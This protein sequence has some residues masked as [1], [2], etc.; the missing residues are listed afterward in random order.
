MIFKELYRDITNFVPNIGALDT[1]NLINNAISELNARNFIQETSLYFVADT[2]QTPAEI[3]LSS[4]SSTHNTYKGE[5]LKVKSVLNCNSY[6]LKRKGYGKEYIENIASNGD[7][8]YGQIANTI[9][10]KVDSDSYGY[11]SYNLTVVEKTTNTITDDDDGDWTTK[12]IS[13]GSYIG[14]TGLTESVDNG[15]YRVAEINDSNPGVTSNDEIK[16]DPAVKEIANGEESK[17]E[18]AVYPL[19]RVIAFIAIPQFS[20]NSGNPT[21][22]N[23][24]VQETYVPAIRYLVLSAIYD[25]DKYD[26]KRE[27]MSEHYLNKAQAEIDLL[28]DTSMQYKEQRVYKSV[29]SE[30]EGD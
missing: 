24:E 14:V 12:G 6:A 4:V 17:G 8:F 7:L 25:S 19:Y 16:V 21:V 28:E 18:C 29:K 1:M 2:A 26:M 11:D 5:I 30:E 20:W 10:I 9:Y 27:S 3:D 22:E 23:V 13:V 15:V